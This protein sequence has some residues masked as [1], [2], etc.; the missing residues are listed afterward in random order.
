L[1]E[2][3]IHPL[4]GRPLTIEEL[5]RLPTQRALGA[6]VIHA[7]VSPWH[8]PE[9]IRAWI[10]Q[11]IATLAEAQDD[12]VRAGLELALRH[13]RGWLPYAEKRWAIGKAEGA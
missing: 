7:P 10:E 3:P 1:N 6:V 9:E 8:H 13:A 11:L 5:R 2:R 12:G 4:S